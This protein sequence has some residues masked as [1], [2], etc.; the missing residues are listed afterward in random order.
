[1]RNAGWTYGGTNCFHVLPELRHPQEKCPDGLARPLQHPDPQTERGDVSPRGPGSAPASGLTVWPDPPALCHNP[2]GRA[3]GPLRPSRG[4][5]ASV[6]TPA[7]TNTAP[8]GFDPAPFLKSLTSK[9]GVYRLLDSRGRILYVGKAR[10][11]KKRVSSYFRPSHQLEPKTRSMVAQAASVDVTVTRTEGEAL[12]LEN[13]LIKEYK[14]RYNIVLRDDKSYPYIYVSLHEQFPRLAFHRGARKGAGRYFGPY[15][16]AGAV[17][18]TLNLLQKLFRVRQCED[19]FFRNRIRPCL[20]Y[21]IQRCTAPCV[22]LVAPE[23]YAQDVRHAVMFL[24]GKSDEVV[25]D[26]GKRMEGASRTLAFEQA[27]RL[28]DQIARLRRVQN[29]QYITAMGGNLDVVAAAC[30]GGVGCVQVFFVRDGRLLGNKAYFPR[31]TLDEDEASVLRAFLGQFY[32]SGSP[33]RSVPAEV[34]VS[35]PLEDED[36]LAEVLSQ[37]AQRRVSIASRLR[38]ERARWI[39]MAVENARLAI[40][41]RLASADNLRARFEALRTS[42]ALDETPSRVECFDI[43]H[44]QGESTVASCVVFDDEGPAKAD[45]RR[46]NIEDIAPGDDYAAIHQALRRRYARLRREEGRLPDLLLI[47]GGKGQAHEAAKVLEELQIDQVTILGV[48][49]GPARKAG[50]ESLFLPGRKAPLILPPDSPALHLI[51]QIRDEAH[52]FAITGHRRRR[53]STRRTS[54]LEEIPG[55]GARR[56]QR[57]LR[58]F[59]GLQGV[60]RAGVEDLAGVEGISNQLARK[61]YDALHADS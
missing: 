26:L 29:R 40:G 42:L 47:D 20:Q 51:Q 44:T 12:L 59:G 24:E 8:S 21:Q 10:N 39:A 9:P 43:S 30:E 38:G 4:R 31:H 58:R 54:V 48:A 6:F 46:F 53:A 13:N 18:E 28:R 60:A 55:I 17:R 11:L 52:R 23:A 34:L 32:L 35:H 16:S 1:V 41:Q 57:L 27:A 14:P 3:A 25:D 50:L 19:S 22:G 15:P 37:H 56:R 7:M 33:D 36:T 45:Y 61:I 5:P 49:K 2:R